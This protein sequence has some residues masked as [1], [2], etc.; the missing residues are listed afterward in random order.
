MWIYVLRYLL[1]IYFFENLLGNFS[2]YRITWRLYYYKFDW[3]FFEEC[4]LK[5]Y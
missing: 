3:I 1:G 2:T 4:I 5:F